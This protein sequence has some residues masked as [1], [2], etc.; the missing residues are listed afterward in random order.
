V[1]LFFYPG[2][3]TPSCTTEA[4]DFSNLLPRFEAAGATVLGLSTGGVAT[5]D[6]FVRKAGLAMPLLAD[7]EERLARTTAS[8]AARITC[9][10]RPTMQM[11]SRTILI[12][13][14][15][16]WRG[17]LAR[18]PA[19]HRGRAVELTLAGSVHAEMLLRRRDQTAVDA[20]ERRF[21]DYGCA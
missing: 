1:V 14:D 5:K 18:T 10:A 17:A 16:P 2:D 9:S 4:Q 11:H 21:A 20:L 13:A 8:L 15:G 19:V 6:K 7:E 3:S 12:D